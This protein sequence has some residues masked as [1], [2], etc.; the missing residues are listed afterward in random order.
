MGAASRPHFKKIKEGIFVRT[1]KPT[2]SHAA[3]I[4]MHQSVV[5]IA[6][7]EV[8]PRS[9]GDMVKQGKSLEEIKKEFAHAGIRRLGRQRAFPQPY[10][11]GLPGSKAG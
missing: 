10:R 1:A 4:L 9:S 7:L 8:V 2:D 6:L 11:G 5:P 3:I